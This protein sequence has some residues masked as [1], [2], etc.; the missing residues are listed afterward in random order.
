VQGCI[1]LLTPLASDYYRNKLSFP[2][3]QKRHHRSAGSLPE[4]LY[5]LVGAIPGILN[6]QFYAWIM[7]YPLN[8]LQDSYTDTETQ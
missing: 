8:W 4:Q 3:Y 6:P 1:W 5:R 2:M 7:G